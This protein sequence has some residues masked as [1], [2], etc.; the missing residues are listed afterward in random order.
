M[1]CL[2]IG[3]DYLLWA[4][5]YDVY[6]VDGGCFIAT[7]STGSTASRDVVMLTKFRDETLRKSFIGRRII[8]CYETIA[9]P[10]AKWLEKGIRRRL[11]VKKYVISPIASFVA[12][13][14]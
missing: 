9:P 1:F 5:R 8:S 11:F 2:A 10:L 14:F 4:Q 12:R 3:Y 6:V 7:A 13:W